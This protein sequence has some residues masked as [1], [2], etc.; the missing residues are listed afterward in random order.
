MAKFLKKFDCKL[1]DLATNFHGLMIEEEAKFFTI[2]GFG[3]TKFWYITD[4][5]QDGTYP[6]HPT[7]ERGGVYEPKYVDSNTKVT[8]HF[9]VNPL[10]Q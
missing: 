8:I 1:Y 5:R 2:D 3:E 6:C 7:D 9:N 4:V 10:Y